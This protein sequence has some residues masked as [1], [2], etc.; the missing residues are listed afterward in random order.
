MKKRT[1]IVLMVVQCS[2]WWL[3]WLFSW[4]NLDINERRQT[5]KAEYERIIRRAR[6]CEPTANGCCWKRPDTKSTAAATSAY[7][8]KH[9]TLMVRKCMRTIFY[10]ILI[11][12]ASLFMIF[13]SFSLFFI[14]SAS[15]SLA[16]CVTQT[17]TEQIF[18]IKLNWYFI[19]ILC[20]V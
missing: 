14:L 15:R 12:S 19:G 6:N 8:R 1:K 20:E 2:V 3:W 10:M 4:S 11:Y 16:P 18:S 5:E 7:Q 13:F 9:I 17:S